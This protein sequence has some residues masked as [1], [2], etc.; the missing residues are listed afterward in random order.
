MHFPSLHKKSILSLLIAP[1]VLAATGTNKYVVV[2]IIIIIIWI[3]QVCLEGDISKQTMINSL[4]R[5]KSAYGDLIPWTIA[6]QV[7]WP[8]GICV[9]VLISNSDQATDYGGILSAEWQRC[10]IGV[11]KN[12]WFHS[13]VANVCAFFFC[14]AVEDSTFCSCQTPMVVVYGCL[15]YS[16]T[17]RVIFYYSSTRY[18]LFPVAV[19]QSVDALLEFMET[20]GFV[21]SFATC[22]SGN[23]SEYIHVQVCL[24]KALTLRAPGTLTHHP[25][26]VIGSLYLSTA[27]INEYL[28]TR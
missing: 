25:F 21:V 4:S 24:F 13:G 22:Q 14:S 6:Q 3:L 1:I 27:S 11:W 7:G 8:V 2:I 12:R 16:S 10:Q 9:H 5:G 19:L 17:T 26:F 20:W 18:F 28:S 23:R 15:E